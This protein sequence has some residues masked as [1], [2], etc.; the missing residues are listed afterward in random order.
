MAEVVHL[1]VQGA[2]VALQLTF[3]A[4]A[5]VAVHQ[6]HQEV[7]GVVELEAQSAQVV[8]EEEATQEHQSF[9]RVEAAEE[10][11]QARRLGVEVAAA[12]EG[13]NEQEVGVGALLVD[14]GPS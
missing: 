3:L 7:E 13:W 8:V 4:A 12:I 10:V 2:E 11:R 9:L 6:N 5:A 14:H 1:Q